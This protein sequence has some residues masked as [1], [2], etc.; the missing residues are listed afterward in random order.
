MYNYLP[1]KT[2]NL[3][4]FFQPQN[5]KRHPTFMRCNIPRDQYNKP[6]L[7][8]QKP[9]DVKVNDCDYID[10]IY[11]NNSTNGGIAS[12]KN[13]DIESE[14]RRINHKADK[15]YYNNYKL[16]PLGKEVQSSNSPLKCHKNIFE[17]NQSMFYKKAEVDRT[18]RPCIKFEK[19]NLCKNTPVR[20]QHLE[21]YDFGVKGFCT[22]HPCQR[23]FNNVTK[24]NMYPSQYVPHDLNKTTT[25]VDY[26]NMLSQEEKNNAKVDKFFEEDIMCMDYSIAPET[27]TVSNDCKPSVIEWQYQ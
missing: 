22:E 3:D 15:C 4:Q 26:T 16:D 19:F 2:N 7:D 9:F 10:T 1:A 12:M 23:L 11:P 18:P 21:L 17:I 27:N 8:R 5:I 24:R 6:I 14:L 25:N 13:I 20:S